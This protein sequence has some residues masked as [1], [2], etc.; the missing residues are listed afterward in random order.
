M[1]KNTNTQTE[2]K[3]T[4]HIPYMVSDSIR[5]Q[6]INRLFD[7]LKPKKDKNAA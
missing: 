3:L 1:R 4:I 7:I 6:K 2:F 5:Q